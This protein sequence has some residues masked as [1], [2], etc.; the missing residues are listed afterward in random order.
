M[1]LDKIE[2][3]EN[4]QT[5][6]GENIEFKKFTPGSTPFVPAVAGY[7]MGYWVVKKN[8]SICSNDFV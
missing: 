5:A 7:F 1:L 8:C 6:K 2:S 4:I 3:I